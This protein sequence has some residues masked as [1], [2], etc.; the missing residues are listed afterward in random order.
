[1][2]PNEKLGRGRHQIHG[3]YHGRDGAGVVDGGGQVAGVEVVEEVVVVERGR[4]CVERDSARDGGKWLMDGGE[5]NAAAAVAAARGLE[6]RAQ[7]YLFL[8]LER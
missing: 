3:S 2:R 6:G 8:G 7:R 5:T 4:R 1:M